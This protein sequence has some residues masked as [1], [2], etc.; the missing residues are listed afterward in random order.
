[1]VAV[2]AVDA[3][4]VRPACPGGDMLR[5]GSVQQRDLLG[6]DALAA[7]EDEVGVRVL[8]P[9]GSGDPGEA[10]QRVA[11]A[12]ARRLRSVHA[13]AAESAGP[14]GVDLLQH[15]RLPGD[16]VADG[17][18]AGEWATMCSAR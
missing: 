14:G 4:Q 10:F 2:V 12:R 18:L 17:A 13:A 15:L 8:I 7:E 6:A 11:S 3:V 9:P 1:M 5:V 16:E